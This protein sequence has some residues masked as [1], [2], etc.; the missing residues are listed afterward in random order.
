M[1]CSGPMFVFV[2]CHDRRTGWWYPL[3]RITCSH[4]FTILCYVLLR[5]SR[6]QHAE[7]SEILNC[8]IRSANEIVRCDVRVVDL[9]KYLSE[10]TG[11]SKCLHTQTDSF[12]LSNA[13]LA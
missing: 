12:I 6:P 8:Q 10:R 11:C 5:N 7:T 3:W 1:R 9:R 2:V 13:M 4:I